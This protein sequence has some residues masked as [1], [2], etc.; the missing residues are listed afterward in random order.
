MRRKNRVINWLDEFYYIVALHFVMV[1]LTGIDY[2]VHNW[3]YNHGLKFSYSWAWPYWIL[4][5]LT[6]LGLGLVGATAYNIDRSKEFYNL[7]VKPRRRK[8]FAVFITIFGEYF[9]GFLDTLWFTI[10]GLAG[11]G[12]P[13]TAN[14]W[15]SPW[16][17]IF[18]HW[19]LRMNIVLNVIAGLLLIALWWRVKK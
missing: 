5:T 12:V 13:W 17:T 19:D 15:W 10:H 7:R 18:G 11:K 2:I 6:F 16:S 3:L 8:L 14:W 9:F 1:T 4:L